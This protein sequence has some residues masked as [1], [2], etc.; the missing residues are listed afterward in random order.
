MP[1]TRSPADSPE[2]LALLVMTPGALLSKRHTLESVR[3]YSVAGASR[4]SSA[5]NCGR[6]DL[7]LVTTRLVQSGI[8]TRSAHPPWV[9][10]AGAAARVACIGRL[11]SRRIVVEEEHLRPSALAHE[12]LGL[13]VG[14]EVARR[15]GYTTVENVVVVDGRAG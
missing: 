2:I 12:N 14:V 11:R 7:S 9:S 1:T 3:A 15:Q 8:E 5:S 13:R 10:Q 4:S 6:Q